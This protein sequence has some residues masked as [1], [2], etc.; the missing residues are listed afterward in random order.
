MKAN[1]LA[2][3]EELHEEAMAATGLSD[4]GDPI[5]R[6]GLRQLLAARDASGI[7]YPLDGETILNPI[8]QLLATR[9][10]TIDRVV[11]AGS[12]PPV[13]APMFVLGLPR[14]G[15][16]AMQRLLMA[17]PQMQGLEYWLGATPKPRPPRETWHS[18]PDYVACKTGIAAMAAI[19][20]NVIK[21]H[22]MAAD[23]GEECRLVMEQSFGHSSFSLV[24][25]LRP[26]QD[27]LF[28]ADLVPHYHH[29]KNALGLIG[30]H[31][32]GKTW[33][34]KC[35]HHAPQVKSLLAVF[36]DAHII[37]MHRPVEALVPSVGR[38]AEAFLALVEGPGVDMKARAALIVENIDLTLQRLLSARAAHAERVFNLSMDRFVADPLEAV[39]AAYTHFGISMNDESREA[40]ARWVSHNHGSRHD[41]PASD[42]LPYG[43]DRNALR[44]RFSYYQG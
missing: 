39:D 20:P 1:F 8:R 25:P 18:D 15:T 44:E 9:L 5:Y 6:D 36:P 21:L 40:L 2:R 29:F 43:L 26:Y 22:P 10:V 24:A 38:L 7:D 13:E 41:A 23:E 35:P 33:V 34:L 31:D 19:A 42:A 11:Q 17:D 3:E 12:L 28:K 30:A 37:L 16:T 32:P 14:T 27:W 4:F